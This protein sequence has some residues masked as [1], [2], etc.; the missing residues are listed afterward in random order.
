MACPGALCARQSLKYRSIQ[1]RAVL[2]D[3]DAAIFITFALAHQHHA[4]GHVNIIN[5]QMD[6]FSTSDPG[7]VEGFDDAAVLQ[8][9]RTIQIDDV[10][11]T[12]DF[13][14]TQRVVG[15]CVGVFGRAISAAGLT[16]IQRCFVS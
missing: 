3:G 9:R 2:T 16:A 14:L 11:H 6:E 13:H 10:D 8:A 1:S 7:A 4:L 15:E 12:L 5:G